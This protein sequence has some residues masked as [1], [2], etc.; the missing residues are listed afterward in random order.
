M[1]DGIWDD[2]TII[3]TQEGMVVMVVVGMVMTVTACRA[4]VMA[5]LRMQVGIDFYD[6]PSLIVVVMVVEDVK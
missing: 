1:E 5:G 2:K 6:T 4:G 3:S